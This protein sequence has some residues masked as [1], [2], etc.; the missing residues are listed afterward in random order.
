METV[1]FERTTEDFFT[2]A[3]EV[4]VEGE[5]A[6][7]LHYSGTPD[8]V[9]VP[10]LGVRRVLGRQDAYGATWLDLEGGATCRIGDGLFLVFG[11][12][13][14]VTLAAADIGELDD[15]IATAVASAT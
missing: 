8:R 3:Q 7:V 4:V 6:I 13:I 5:E 11:A 1:W 12:P 2:P 9:K 14:D 10:G 15:L